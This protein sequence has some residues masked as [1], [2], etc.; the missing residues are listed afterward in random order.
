[1]REFHINS[2][3]SF[4]YFIKKIELEF[5]K[6]IKDNLKYD[7]I[8]N[9]LNNPSI[10]QIFP[11]LTKENKNLKQEIIERIKLGRKKVLKVKP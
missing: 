8:L 3:K 10:E 1:M 9:I 6:I 4:K 2:N 5:D 11:N 7:R